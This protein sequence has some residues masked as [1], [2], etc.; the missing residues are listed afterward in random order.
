LQE[1]I[2]HDRAVGLIYDAALDVTRWHDALDAVAQLTGTQTFHL[3]A[4]NAVEARDELG[5]VTDPSWWPALERYNAHFAASD[6]RIDICA[7]LGPG[8]LMVCSEHLDRRTVSRSEIYQDHLIPNGLRYC[9]ASIL[10]TDAEVTMAVGLM[11]PADGGA[12]K[13]EESAAACRLLPHLQRAATLTLRER[14]HGQQ[15]QL[16]QAAGELT[17]LALITISADGRVLQANPRGEALLR[18][19]ALLRLH[20]GRL[21]ATAPGDVPALEEA[22]QAVGRN[23]VPRNLNLI[24]PDA[25]I[26]ACLT[27]MRA[28]EGSAHSRGAGLRLL[29]VVAQG[30]QRVASVRQLMAWFGLTPAE[31]RLARAL[32]QAGDLDAYARET[33]LTRNTVKSHLAHLMSKLGVSDQRELI[34]RVLRLPAVRG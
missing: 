1:H 4:W 18:D 32:A 6:P 28:P 8:A 31:A 11:R 9:M 25:S 20:R 26:D 14:G 24:A 10:A 19:Q 29:C 13:H 3:G 16:G 34:R 27:L 15:Q 21:R 23:G 5:I 2:A 22:V 12:W 7:Q 33:G 30:R 17:H